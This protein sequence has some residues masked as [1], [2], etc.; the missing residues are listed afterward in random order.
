MK[1][2]DKKYLLIAATSLLLTLPAAS[3][4]E[5]AVIVNNQS[6]LSSI[7]KSDMKLVYLGK[8]SKIAGV[9][10]IP[11]SLPDEDGATQ[12]FLSSVV[13]KTTK[14]YKAYWAR[15]VFSGKGA[16]PPQLEDSAELKAWVNKNP[17]GIGFI[18]SKD[19]DDTI[20]VA[21]TF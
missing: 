5:I 9:K 20:K 7:E 2:T 14:Q 18:N 6:S 21:A 13:E 1:F 4:A 17:E 19:V 16:P 8:R 10:V 11:V 12:E 15:L 3:M